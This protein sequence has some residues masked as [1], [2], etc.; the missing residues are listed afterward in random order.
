MIWE[1][2]RTGKLVSKKRHREKR[3]TASTS[4]KVIDEQRAWQ[5]VIDERRSMDSWL[6]PLRG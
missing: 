1:Q 2:R 5:A 4:A 6:T 3:Q